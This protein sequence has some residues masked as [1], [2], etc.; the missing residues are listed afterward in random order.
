MTSCYIVLWI[1]LFHFSSEW[2]FWVVRGHMGLQSLSEKN[3]VSGST[4]CERA[5]KTPLSCSVTGVEMG[6]S[7]NT[8]VRADPDHLLLVFPLFLGMDFALNY[9]YGFL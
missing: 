4:G 1:V 5:P 2:K 9:C 7:V 6:L 8:Q 3:F